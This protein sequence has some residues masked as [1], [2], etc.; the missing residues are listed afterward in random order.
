MEATLAVRAAGALGETGLERF[1]LAHRALPGIDLTEVTLRTTLLGAELAAPVLL[2]GASARVAT[3]L[4]LG[5][6]ANELAPDRP[7]LWLASLPVS[8]LRA[9]GVERAERL[10]AGLETDG[11]VLVLD[12]MEDPRMRGIETAIAAAV[13]RLAPLPVVIR[14]GGYGLDAADVR[15]LVSVG[16]AAVDVGGAVRA[17]WGV[18]TADAVAEAVLAAPGLPVLADVS[19]ALDAAKC[20][21]LGASAVTLAAEDVEEALADLRMALWSTGVRSPGEL[22]PGYLRERPTAV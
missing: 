4:R 11:L 15:E 1:R 17:G 13:E 18:P 16:A 6:V 20:L 8:E 21:A 3:E 19:G 22:S 10:V 5:L 12:G 2:A 9:A 7:P 14:G